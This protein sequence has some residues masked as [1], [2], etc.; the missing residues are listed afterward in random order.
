ML[1]VIVNL[2][3]VFLWINLVWLCENSPQR[4]PKGFPSY[5]SCSWGKPPRPH[6]RASVT[7]DLVGFHQRATQRLPPQSP[8]QGRWRIRAVQEDEHR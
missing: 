8:F 2:W 7:C 3:L 5:E 4:C 6:F 1:P